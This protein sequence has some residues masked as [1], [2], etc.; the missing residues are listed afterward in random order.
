MDL[1]VVGS[2]RITDA[3]RFGGRVYFPIS[4]QDGLVVFESPDHYVLQVRVA[5]GAP[6]W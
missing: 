2:L 5:D 6:E 3:I 4:F 1:Q